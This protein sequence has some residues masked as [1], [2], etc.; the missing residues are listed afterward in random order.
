[1]RSALTVNKTTLL[2]KD[3]SLETRGSRHLQS[4]QL[5]HLTSLI[6]VYILIP[7]NMATKTEHSTLHV[8]CWYPVLTGSIRLLV[9]PGGGILA[10]IVPESLMAI[11][12]VVVVIVVIV[13]FSYLCLD[14]GIGF[15]KRYVEV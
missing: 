8:V 15:G 2:T 9:T 10:G 1:M 14:Y 11:V 4:S 6:R 13:E 3:L 12:V 5:T 7:T